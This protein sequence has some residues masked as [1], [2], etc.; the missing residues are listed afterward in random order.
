M[1][2]TLARENQVRNIRLVCV[3]L[4]VFVAAAIWAHWP[5]LSVEC[6]RIKPWMMVGLWSGDVF[7]LFWFVRFIFTHALAGE[8]LVPIPVQDA[9]QQI[10]QL[11]TMGLIAL[12]A[13][14]GFSL[15][16]MWDEHQAYAKAV[17][18]QAE[19]ARVQVIKRPE[20]TWYELNFRFKA[21][22]G[23]Y[24]EAHMRVGA[25]GHVLPG[26]L[27]LEVV[28]LLSGQKTNQ[29]NIPIRYDP[30][31]PSRAW[32]DG[33]G[34]ED[35]NGIYWFS[36]GVLLVQGALTLLFFL[37]IVRHAI[38]GSLPWW[39]DIFK[40]IPIVSEAFLMLMGGLIDRFMDAIM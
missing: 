1:L 23:A 36:I 7:G 25:K 26:N 28:A 18:I 16:L 27:P 30:K 37:F 24:H 9:R 15:Y 5:Y 11:V 32:I 35:G 38:Q 3:A 8:P 14:F 29:S 19:V 40:V 4:T 2:T 6:R 21:N 31:F 10:R 39:W 13:D 20:Y 33:A 17:P 12:A 22:D 34:W